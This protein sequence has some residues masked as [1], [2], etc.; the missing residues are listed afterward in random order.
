MTYEL[1]GDLIHCEATKTLHHHA[2]VGIGT[3]THD[4]FQYILDGAEETLAV[5]WLGSNGHASRLLDDWPFRVH[6]L[7]GERM[8]QGL[9]RL[10]DIALTKGVQSIYSGL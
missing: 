5:Q 6:T 3:G 10:G 8:L 4:S 7:G 9:P 2:T 1:H